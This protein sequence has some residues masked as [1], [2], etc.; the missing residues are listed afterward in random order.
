MLDAEV[1]ERIAS[2]HEVGAGWS[3]IARQLNADA[4]RTAHGGSRWYPSTV[5]AVV[6]AHATSA[7]VVVI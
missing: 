6:L 5:R 3:E 7:G 1:T 2:A 4:E